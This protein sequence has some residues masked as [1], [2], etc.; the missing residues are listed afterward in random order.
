MAFQR[1]GGW[2][3]RGSSR[4][5][6]KPSSPNMPPRSSDAPP[7]APT[8]VPTS[9]DPILQSFLD[10]GWQID[11]KPPPRGFTRL[12]KMTKGLREEQTIPRK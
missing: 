8:P 1:K 11:R 2:K 3:K 10:R 7:D 9:D 6:Y 12:F 5:R 4:E